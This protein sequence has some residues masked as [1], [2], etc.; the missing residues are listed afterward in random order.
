MDSTRYSQ[1]ASTKVCGP[2]MANSSA[3]HGRERRDAQPRNTTLDICAWDVE[4]PRMV[5]RDVLE[6]RQQNPLMPYRAEVWE[7]ELE[8]AGLSDCFAKVPEGFC[9]GFKIDFPSIHAVHSPPNRDS[10][11]EYKTE[12]DAIIQKELERGRYIGPFTAEVLE[13]L[14]GPFQ[15]SPLSIIPK[16]GKCGKFRLVQNFSFPHSYSPA[17]PN[18]S[19]NSNIDAN[20]FP[21]TWGKFS[22][23]F[24]LIA[25]LPPGSEVATRDITEAYRTVPLHPS[26]WPAGVVRILETLFCVDICTAFGAS[27]SAGAYGHVADA[28]AEIFRYHGIGP[29]DK[30]VDDHIFFRIRRA[31]L[32]EYNQQ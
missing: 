26:Q 29:L 20:N 4:P 16:P 2:K 12:F 8:C 14:I 27:L 18:P 25:T 22:I 24:Q 7:H 6:H 19:I 3:L 28:A 10:I 15:S 9:S 11:S 30:W 1:S 23:I 32:Q 17:F 13:Q 31:Y 5:P 21:T